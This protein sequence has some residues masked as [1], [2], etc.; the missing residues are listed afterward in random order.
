MKNTEYV[1]G[2]KWKRRAYLF[3]R[4]ALTPSVGSS[5]WDGQDT[6][7][8]YRLISFCYSNLE[9]QRQM[10]WTQYSWCGL[11]SPLPKPLQ[12]IFLKGLYRKWPIDVNGRTFH[13]L[14]SGSPCESTLVVGNV[15][16][17][18]NL[19]LSDPSA[20]SDTRPDLPT[21]QKWENDEKNKKT[22][23]RSFTHF[24]PNPDISSSRF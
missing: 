21:F 7:L 24:R 4:G 13:R 6:T 20:T 15:T 9:T 12:R 10:A 14:H 17:S 11:A 1:A 2:E 22:N 3:L 8:I 23:V 5:I 16:K 18:C 19:S